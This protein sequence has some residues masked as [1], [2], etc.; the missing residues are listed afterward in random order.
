M[1]NLFL[2]F[3]LC[4]ALQLSAQ[5]ITDQRY[6][7]EI[8]ETSLEQALYDLAELTGVPI[9]FSNSTLPR[10]EN[11]TY[12]FYQKRLE[13]IL[14]VLLDGTGFHHQW[15]GKQVV[16]LPAPAL[17]L[18]KYSLSGYVRD[19]ISGEPLIGANVY[20]PKLEKGTTTNAYGYYSLTLPEGPMSVIF[21]Y[22]GFRMRTLPIELHSNQVINL[23]L[24]PSVTLQEVVVTAPSIPASLLDPTPGRQFFRSEEMALLPSLNGE[25]DLL[26]FTYLQ[27]GVQTGADGFGG[28]SV[29]GGDVDQNLVLLDGVPVYNATHMLGVF[30]VFNNS[31]IQ[32]VQ[33]LKGVFP[34]RYGGRVSSV[35]DVRTKEGNNKHWEGEADL[36]IASGKASIEGPLIKERCSVFIGARRSLIDLYSRPITRSMWEKRGGE[37]ELGYNFFDLNAKI[38]FKWGNRDHLYLS[39]YTGGDDYDNFQANATNQSDS[40]ILDRAVQE[41]DWG[42]TI[43]SLRWNHLFNEKLFSNTT[44]TYSR[45]FYGSQDSYEE[46]LLEQTLL[47]NRE[48][49]FFRYNSNNRD[50]AIATDFDL[51]PNPDHTIRFGANLVY[52]HFQPGGISFDET[53]QSDTLTAENIEFLLERNAQNTGEYELYIEDEF[54]WSNE[55]GGNA[56]LRATMLQVNGALLT[57][58]QPRVQVYYHPTTDWLLS[59]GVGRL[60]QPLHLLTNSGIGLPRDLWV[61]STSRIRPIDSWQLTGGIHWNPTPGWEVNIEGFY[62]HMNNLTTFQEGLLTS[63]DATNWQNK[64]AVGKGWSYGAEWLLKRNGR[65]LSGW[66]AYTLSYSRRQFE[67][68][69]LG[70]SFPFRFDRRHNLHLAGALSLGRRWQTSL[71]WTFGSGIATTLPRSSYQFN[72]FNL[73]YSDVPPQ[74]PFILE[75]SNFGRKNDIRL[76]NYHRL[77]L[78]VDYSW[79][80]KQFRHQ[81][82]VGVYNLYNRFN[83]LYYILAERLDETTGH[84]A[85]KY[86]EVALLPAMP[87]LRYCVHWTGEKAH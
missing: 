87:T 28:L 36:G 24:T 84:Y 33:F 81:L 74:F 85:P 48:Y 37:G 55:I 44:I 54:Q 6:D 10:I 58:I 32:S 16:I 66:L 52:H 62:K 63:I 60:V 75:V 59:I 79:Q 23:E 46:K 45:F 51:R 8:R 70:E 65:R 69:N 13:E 7:W 82:S 41:V 64:V 56:G 78:E 80:K 12:S 2:A 1:R 76:P 39:F 22:L 47:L 20:S 42:N 73:L 15:I 43:G 77:D 86:L 31:A 40:I 4:G 68:V 18:K 53:V 30:S 29:R 27:P 83:P 57:Y 38:N 26:R 61:S 17:V 9:A 19:A 5:P 72:Q 67:E 3:I 71:V 14:T 34:A 25:P 35:V 11:L 21:S 49:L 50:L